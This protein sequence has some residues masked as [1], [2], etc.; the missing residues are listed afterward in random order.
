MELS[1]SEQEAARAFARLG[2]LKGGKARAK[3]LTPEERSEIAREGAAARWA[4]QKSQDGDSQIA[5]I[6]R[7]DHAGHL[8][9]GNA[10]IPCY[11][12]D[13]ETRILS[14]RG[15]MK[16]LERRWRGRKYAGTEL[17]VFLEASNLK[18]FIP[19][20]L[21]L[22]FSPVIFRTDKGARSEGYRAEILPEICEV[23]LK[24][25]D[26]EKL[27][28]SQQPIAQRCQIL[29]RALSKVG[30]IALV[31]E[32]TGYQEVRDRL[33]LQAILDLYL[34]KDFAKW[35]K[36]F[37]PNFYQGIFRLRNWQWRGMKVN[38]PQIVAHYTKDLV[39]AR[40]AP[41]IVK[42]LEVRNPM[43]E[44]GYR[45]H[46]HYQYLTEDIGL[47]A[48]AQHLYA[49]NGLM[50]AS[51]TWKEFMELMDK[52]HPRRGDTLQLALFDGENFE[53]SE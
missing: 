11:V 51:N 10:S 14:T 5:T 36:Q 27:T 50:R 12:L 47:P 35:A 17:P 19:E 21:G 3:A 23:Y 34:R 40:L 38:P 33:A 2:G 25:L 37:P 26:Q 53:T 30:I 9:I 46:K 41:G 31:D 39:Y 42:E 45:K 4:K 28:K 29:M 15:I 20:N 6:P 43:T 16:G 32:A 48:L 18:P 22:V 7:A 49:V 52:A 44:R 13:N 24:A 8:H 1:K